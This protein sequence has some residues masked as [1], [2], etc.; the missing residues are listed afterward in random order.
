MRNLDVG[1]I[2]QS[3]NLIADMTVYENVEYLPICDVIAART[4]SAWVLLKLSGE[5]T[6]AGRRFDD[7]SSV[8]L[9][10]GHAGDQT[11]RSS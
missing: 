10:I 6:R 9:T 11:V 4:T 8:K 2:F 1:L 5:R 7:V 3:F